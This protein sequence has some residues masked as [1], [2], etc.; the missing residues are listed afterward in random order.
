MDD[1]TIEEICNE[2]ATAREF[3]ENDIQHRNG[4]KWNNIMAL[5]LVFVK[6][7]TQIHLT[8]KDDDLS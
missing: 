3:I 2:F 1:M 7:L 4:I 8:I 6:N 5:G